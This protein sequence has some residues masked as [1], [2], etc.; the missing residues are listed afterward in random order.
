MKRFALVVVLSLLP[1]S[2]FAATG[3]S[4]LKIGVG[5]RYTAMGETSVAFVDDAFSPF[6]NPAG[7]SGVEATDVAFSH[8]AWFQDVRG[9]YVAASVPL[10]RVRLGLF[11][12]YGSVGGIEK[13]GD[14]PTSEPLFTF[15]AHESIF[16]VAVASHVARGIDAGA[17]VRWVYEK[18]DVDDASA[19]ALDIGLRWAV[20]P[21]LTVGGAVQHFGTEPTFV[22]ESFSLPL[23]V[24]VGG[25]W[26]PSLSS[27]FDFL[28]ATDVVMVRD[29]DAVVNLGGEAWYAGTLALRGGYCFG[30][31]TR[32]LSGGAGLSWRRFRFD[33]AFV[34]YGDD[35][36]GTHR[37]SLG[38]SL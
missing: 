9:E 24:R 17:S 23:T 20:L 6:W 13:R 34:P 10:G 3:M 37:F 36:G 31:D 1:L 38:V 7:L 28:F 33:Y 15:S 22:S 5:S 21:G 2:A 8:A 27:V 11:G 4:F 26:R 19:F 25:A 14:V 12:A 18:I 35:L 30:H 32:S 16:G 29:E